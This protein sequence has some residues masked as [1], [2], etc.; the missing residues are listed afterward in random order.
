MTPLYRYIEARTGRRLAP[1]LL[2]AVY[3]AVLLSIVLLTGYHD[4]GQILY[5]DIP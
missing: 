5:L 1:L 3:A 2:A 4:G